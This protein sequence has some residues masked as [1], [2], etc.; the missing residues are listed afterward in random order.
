M[1]KKRKERKEVIFFTKY[2]G[3]FGLDMAAGKG[4]RLPRIDDESAVDGGSL[5]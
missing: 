2:N 1:K 3:N 5:P 4:I